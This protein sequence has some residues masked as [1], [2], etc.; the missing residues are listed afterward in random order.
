LGEE[1]GHLAPQPAT[2]RPLLG[3]SG[4]RPGPAL[5]AGS[6]KLREGAALS[7]PRLPSSP[8]W[9]P[10]PAMACAHLLLTW[11]LYLPFVLLPE[12][13]T[14]GLPPA[15]QKASAQHH[16]AEGTSPPRPG[17]LQVHDR[18]LH[19]DPS[20]GHLR[21]SRGG[22]WAP[23]SGNKLARPGLRP[24]LLSQS[25]LGSGSREASE[26]GHVTAA[27]VAR[28]RRP[29]ACAFRKVSTPVTA[30]ALDLRTCRQN[31]Q[32]SVTPGRII[33]PG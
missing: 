2:G 27:P 32:I 23:N 18:Q 14:F 12:S 13:L 15:P 7:P 10:P 22:S 33:P 28:R 6:D 20:G 19:P 4:R 29:A 11:G 16:P 3:D 21:D 25:E 26:R 1:R 30:Q 9:A 5:P 31:V 17:H 24:L 8:A